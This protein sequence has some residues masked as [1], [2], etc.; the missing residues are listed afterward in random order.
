MLLKVEDRCA[1][2]GEKGYKT[3]VW[4]KFVS[5]DTKNFLANILHFQQLI[6]RTGRS[7]ILWKN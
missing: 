7:I 2:V 6:E 4:K 3:G 1:N 5:F